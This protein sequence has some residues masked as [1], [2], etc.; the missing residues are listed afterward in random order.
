[1]WPYSSLFQ[2]LPL[3]CS[4]NP[5][6]DVTSQSYMT[7]ALRYVTQRLHQGVLYFQNSIRVYDAHLNIISLPLHQCCYC[8]I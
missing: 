5:E 4:R 3:Q 1:M 8:G 7:A 2:K 6:N